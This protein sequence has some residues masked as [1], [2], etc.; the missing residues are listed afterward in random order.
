MY[1]KKEELE[2]YVEKPWTDGSSSTESDD[3][4]KT[5]GMK[6]KKDE[7]DFGV[8]CLS[9]YAIQKPNKKIRRRRRNL[10]QKIETP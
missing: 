9:E 6:L 8:I 5:V 3:E 7:T 4:Y 1:R 10:K 2:V